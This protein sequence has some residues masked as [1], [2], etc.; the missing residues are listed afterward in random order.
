MLLSA[1][2]P[3]FPTSARP[4]EVYCPPAPLVR[5]LLLLLLLPEA[6]PPRGGEGPLPPPTPAPL[7]LLL[8]PFVRGAA[9]AVRTPGELLLPS[10]VPLRYWCWCWWLLLLLPLGGVPP[11]RRPSL[12]VIFAPWG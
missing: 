3:P 1:G 9:A 10:F 6:T 5:A 4:G 2:P 7:L 12:L 11:P 8:A